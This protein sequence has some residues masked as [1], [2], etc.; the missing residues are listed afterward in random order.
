MHANPIA[1]P[2]I[3][4]ELLSQTVGRCGM[5]SMRLEDVLALLDRNE[6]LAARTLNM[7]PSENSMSTIAKLPLILDVYHRYFFND[8]E[9]AN[10]WNFRGSQEIAQLETQ[11]TLVLLRELT[12][13]TYVNLRPLS[14]L[15]GMTLI[16]AAL[17][18][19]PGSTIL[20]VHPDQG[21]H[22]ATA[23]IAA[24]LGLRTCFMRGPDAHTIDYAAIATILETECPGLVYVDQSNCLFPLDVQQLVQV[25]RSVAPNTL[26]HI[27][28]SHWM[29]LVLGQQFPN[30]LALGADSFGGSMHK[31]FPGPQKAIFATNN[32]AL[33][34]QVRATQFFM[35]SSHHFAAS[36]ALGIA[37]L[38]FK[39][40]GGKEYARTVI[41]NTQELGRQLHD[42]G[43]GVEAV[44]RGFSA[45]HQ[46]WIRTSPLGVDA[47]EVSDKLYA[48]GIR[49]NVFPELPGI[50]ES[51]LRVGVNEATYH[52]FEPTDMPELAD[53]FIAAIRGTMPSEQ[54]VERVHALRAARRMKYCYRSDH[55]LILEQ[56][57]QL[58]AHALVPGRAIDIGSM[59][60]AL[61][62]VD[63]RQSGL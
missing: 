57:V 16:L 1:A 51:V 52:G 59:A 9:A 63:S 24:R 7:V 55:P 10:E 36:L 43:F 6:Q 14:G 2:G 5:T 18:G 62:A 21:G 34:E 42:R 50:N 4:L 48:A 44:E 35:I 20:T 15:S 31:T 29:G 40:C 11:L 45:G 38:E 30:P 22:Y 32:Q 56:V 25:V 19:P 47:F 53:I 8:R 28:A 23:S 39:E 3:N 41:D 26:V 46:L 33:A 12:T 54:L 17:G 58:F 60:D 61:S 49:V 27:D 37:L 13:A